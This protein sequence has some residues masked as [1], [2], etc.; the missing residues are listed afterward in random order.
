[1][2]I[3][4]ILLTKRDIKCLTGYCLKDEPVYVIRLRENNL[5]D[6]LS[7][8]NQLVFKVPISLFTII[9]V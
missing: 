7:I 8:R 1:M 5:I 3:G 6:V 2:T 4:T 9:K